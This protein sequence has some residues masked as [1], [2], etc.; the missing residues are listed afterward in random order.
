M[1]FSLQP[2]PSNKPLPNLIIAGDIARNNNKIAIRYEVTGELKEI[3][4]SPPSNTLARQQKLWQET[5]FE[6][7]L[8]IN[9]SQEYWEFN[10]SPAGHWNVYHFDAYRQGMEE[11][12]DF[13][14]L[15]FTF[16]NQ[17]DRLTL[18]L[19]VDLDKIVAEE[20]LLD[21]AITAVIKQ[22]NGEVSYWALTHRGGE[23]DFHLRE[24]FAMEL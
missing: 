12:V 15:P 18:A 4:I 13:K 11:E 19:D 6:F 20:Q 5:C 22:I 17:A 1:M 3:V 8:G 16:E 24:S 9:N 14:T 23:A 2:F 7:F 21:V 10:L